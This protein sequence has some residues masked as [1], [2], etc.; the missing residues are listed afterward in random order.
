MGAKRAFELFP[1]GLKQRSKQERK[2]RWGQ[3]QREA[4][5]ACTAAVASQKKQVQPQHI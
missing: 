1:G 3:K 5:T 4:V 2:K